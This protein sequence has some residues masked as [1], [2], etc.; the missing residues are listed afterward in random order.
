MMA[1]LGLIDTWSELNPTKRD[2]TFFSHPHSVY[3]R[4]DYFLMFQKDVGSV[5][6]CSIGCMDL[7]DHGPVYI[8]IQLDS[9]KKRTIWRL[10]TGILTQM[11]DQIRTDIT[12]YLEEMITGRCPHQFFGTHQRLS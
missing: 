5:H 4:L 2:F 9:E 6:S 10:N 3:S 12:N 1:K 7:S 11:R 8:V